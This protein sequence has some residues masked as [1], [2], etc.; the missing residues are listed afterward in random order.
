MTN[1]AITT[2]RKLYIPTGVEWDDL[3]KE[4]LL[5]TI[6]EFVYPNFLDRSEQLVFTFPIIEDVGLGKTITYQVTTLGEKARAIID[7]FRLGELRKGQYVSAGGWLRK[8]TRVSEET[9]EEIVIREFFPMYVV[10]RQKPQE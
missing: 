3:Y 6:G 10:Q 5:G 4:N 7:R 1:E 9:G 8:E 2:Y